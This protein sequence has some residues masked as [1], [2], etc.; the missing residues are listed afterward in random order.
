M[1][2][3]KKSLM[4]E[5]ILPM[6]LKINAV[7]QAD[8]VRYRDMP[9]E[10][11]QLPEGVDL[12]NPLTTTLLMMEE[13][14]YLDA[15]D[16]PAAEQVIAR[17]EDPDCSMIGLYRHLINVDKIFLS[18]LKDAEHTDISPL[19]DRQ[20]KSVMRAMRNN[21]SVIRTEYAVA[22]RVRGDQDVTE[23]WLK[24]FERVKKSHPNPVEIQ[25]EEELMALV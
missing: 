18:I 10:W 5:T 8:G 9:A 22:K 16:F 7:S 13:N 17:M 25:T 15:H 12:K 14:R 19:E 11:F 2:K 20:V 24:R 1:T 6:L 21:P 3:K 23:K 4:K